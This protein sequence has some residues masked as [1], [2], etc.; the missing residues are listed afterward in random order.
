MNL[1]L[2]CST[3]NQ[4]VTSPLIFE[5]T[6]SN[7]DKERIIILHANRILSFLDYKMERIHFQLISKSIYIR[8]RPVNDMLTYWWHPREEDRVHFLKARIRGM[9]RIQ[10]TMTSG[11]QKRRRLG[12][13]PTDLHAATRV[14]PPGDAHKRIVASE[15]LDDCLD[16]RSRSTGAIQIG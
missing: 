4:L 1:Y 15:D 12:R 9:K 3:R 16:D 8:I 2:C 6:T 14:V 13:E 10:K 11:R 7:V 5:N